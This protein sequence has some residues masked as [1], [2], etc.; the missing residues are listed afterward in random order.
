[1]KWKEWMTLEGEGLGGLFFFTIQNSPNL[2]EF[3]NCIGGGFWKVLGGLD[4]FSKSHIYCYNSLNIKN[5]LIISIHLSLSTK[6]L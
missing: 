1:M 6:T 3:K 4:Q 5:I 2:G